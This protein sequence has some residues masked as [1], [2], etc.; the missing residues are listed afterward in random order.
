MSDIHKS[1]NYLKRDFESIRQDLV[2]L[3][4]VYYPEQYQDFNAASVGMSLIELLAYVSDLLSYHT[5]KKFNELFLDGITDKVSAFRL[6]KTLGYKPPGFRPALTIAEITVEVPPTADGPD[7]SYLPLYRPGMQVKGAGQIFETVNEIDFSSDFSEDG[8]ANRKIEPIFNAN[9]DILRYRITKLEKLK[10][11]TT[12]IFR[13]EITTEEAA[14]AFLDVFLPEDNVLEIISV[15]EK[16]GTGIAGDPTFA[17]FSDASL[18]YYEVDELAEDKVFVVDDTIPADTGIR[19]G[20]YV[21]V[22]QRFMKEFMADGSCKITFGGGATN[23]EAY[24]RYI[25][26]LTLGEQD[27]VS[28]REVL[29]NNALGARLNPNSTL[30]IKYRIGGGSQTNVGANTLQSV[31]NINAVIQGTDAALN[32]SVI[33]STRAT[34]ILPAIGGADLPTVEEVRYNIAG[35][36]ASQKRCVTLQDYIA[37]S[38]QIPGKFGA[39]F[40]IHGKVEDNKVKLYILTKDSTGKLISNSTSLIKENLKEYLIPFRCINDFVEINDGKVVNISVDIDLYIDKSFNSNEVKVNA[41]N[42][43]KDFFDVNKWQMNQNLYVS[44]VV[45]L[46]REVP[47][48]INVVDIRFYN[49]DGGSYS[50][51][52]LSQATGQRTFV[53]GTSSFRTPIEL[54]NNAIFGTPLSMLE[55]RSPE[56]DIRIRVN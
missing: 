41:I 23:Y 1:Q 30:Y 24:E 11:G 14:T 32:Q 9:Q 4:K 34:N 22:I 55:I 7:P 49:M 46:L 31:A 18:R 21:E 37:R 12:V 20:Q 10:A 13:K 16:P 8:I 40:R 19:A 33:S 35:N 5:D 29:A 47:G 3:L 6:A 42:G 43:V 44:Q 26:N 51:T 39:P 27:R 36:F 53:P 50:S 15:I 17:E 54:V 2:N 38:Y 52:V 56:R 28:I 45:D 25:T 48:V